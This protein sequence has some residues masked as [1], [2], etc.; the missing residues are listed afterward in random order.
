MAAGPDQIAGLLAVVREAAEEAG[1]DPGA[2][3]VTHG[4]P[5]GSEEYARALEDPGEIRRLE[6]AGVDR[7]ILMP[8]ATSAEQVP[9]AL[10]GLVAF[11]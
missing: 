4:I 10:E 8:P 2:I 1:R 3:E 6:E 5:P 7:V 11:V 9:E